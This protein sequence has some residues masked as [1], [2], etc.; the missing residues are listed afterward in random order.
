MNTRECILKILRQKEKN[1]NLSLDTL[2]KE[3]ELNDKEKAYITNVTH[4]VYR[5]KLRLEALIRLYCH[6]ADDISSEAQN[7]LL[8]ALCE[9]YNMQSIPVHA[10]IHEAVE[11]AKIYAKKEVALVN[12]VLRKVDKE[13]PNKDLEKVKY[14]KEINFLYPKKTNLELEA[15]YASLPS[16]ILDILRKQYGK[17]Y[18]EKYLQTLNEIPWYSMRFNALKKDWEEKREEIIQNSSLHRT[19][20]LS[21]FA[22]IS[23][24]SQLKEL[25]TQGYLSYQN[26]SS[27]LVVKKIVDFFK[28]KKLPLWDCCAGVGGK[29]LALAEQGFE[30]LLASDTSKKRIE[31]YESNQERLSIAN[32]NT[33]VIDMREKDIGKVPMI[34]LDAPCSG[35]G[36]LSSNPDLRYKITKRNIQETISLQKELLQQALEKC[37]EKGYICYITCSFNKAENEVLLEN[38]TQK[39]DIL[40]SEYIYPEVY[41]ADTQY[42]AILQKK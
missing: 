27:Q 12:G 38:Y 2:F 42:L 35:L 4:Q 39:V 40:L 1:L 20:A 33:E 34:L 3:N 29:S 14:I 5:Y 37:D 25:Y 18:A 6:K 28:E 13:F 41:G 31:V 26:A 8:L 10:S 23:Q 11:L 30:V 16:F 19:F 22:S 21:G 15:C 36:T 9:M 32:I 24:D 7:I 17:E